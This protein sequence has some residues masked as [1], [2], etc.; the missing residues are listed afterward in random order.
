MQVV[1][2]MALGLEYLSTQDIRTVKLMVLKLTTFSKPPKS[3][4]SPVRRGSDVNLVQVES[5]HNQDKSAVD[6][7]EN[8]KTKL[9][10]IIQI[11]RLN[12][13]LIVLI[14]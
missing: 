6:V 11:Q 13:S 8:Q 2:S 5:P 7:V 1:P 9:R 10:L 4:I 12:F 14:N 3:L